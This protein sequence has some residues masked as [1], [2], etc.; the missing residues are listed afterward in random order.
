V[1]HAFANVKVDSTKRITNM[2]MAMQLGWIDL[3]IAFSKR[4]GDGISARCH[5]DRGH[6]HRLRQHVANR[7]VGRHWTRLRTEQQCAAG[8]LQAGSVRHKGGLLLFCK[9][10]LLLLELFPRCKPPSKRR[11]VWSPP[12]HNDVGDVSPR[13]LASACVLDD[14][15]VVLRALATKGL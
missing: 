9:Q 4:G 15:G 10:K 7:R 1:C 13:L 8:S 11:S 5:D 6:H 3:A 14:G 12:R 2:H